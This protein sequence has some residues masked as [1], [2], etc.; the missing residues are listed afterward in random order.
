MSAEHGNRQ[1]SPEPERKYTGIAGFDLTTAG[2]LFEPKDAFWITNKLNK[3]KPQSEWVGLEIYATR[4]VPLISRIGI[5]AGLLPKGVTSREIYDWQKS[6]FKDTMVLRVNPAFSATKL[7]A[8]HRMT[9]GELKNGPIHMLMQGSWLVGFGAANNMLGVKLTE[10]LRSQDRDQPEQPI[11]SAK[12]NVIVNFGNKG[13][14]A[15]IREKTGGILVGN[16]RKYHSIIVS[17][18]KVIHDPRAIVSQIIERY[19]EVDGLS[20][21]LDHGDQGQINVLDI[22]DDTKVT[23]QVQVIH[24][25]NTARAI[26]GDIQVGDEQI[27]QLI[28]K[29]S[30]VKFVHPVRVAFDY[31]PKIFSK[32]SLQDQLSA[33][34]ELL[35][36]WKT[37]QNDGNSTPRV[38]RFGHRR[39]VP[40]RPIKRVAI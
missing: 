24:I 22:L 11:F 13:M 35:D 8:I 25:A 28:K 36:W 14:L 37:V 23:D 19:P 31:N 40:R 30:T 12:P 32:K 39:Q 26:H 18:Q 2:N 16:E 38:L 5:K 20:L 3:D 21:G 27:A 15:E 29:L 7:E 4:D 33:I 34:A 6:E 9:F 1:S 17:D 10:D